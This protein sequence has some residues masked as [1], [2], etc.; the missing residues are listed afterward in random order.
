M[1][2]VAYYMLTDRRGN[3]LARYFADSAC[4]AVEMYARDAGFADSEEMWI[5]RG[6]LQA[7]AFR[8]VFGQPSIEETV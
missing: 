3:F 1:A 8:V 7:R 2:L 4:E 6:P 5:E